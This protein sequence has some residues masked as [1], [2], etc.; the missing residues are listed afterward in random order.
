VIRYRDLDEA[1]ARANAGDYGLGASV[2]GSDAD[3][4][5]AIADRLD[6]GTVWINAHLVVSPSLPFGGHKSSG[7]GVENGLLGLHEYTRVRVVHR[8]IAK[9][10]AR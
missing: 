6:A 10:G 4:A 1:V 5:A 7:V 3:A 2:W 9:D 8:P